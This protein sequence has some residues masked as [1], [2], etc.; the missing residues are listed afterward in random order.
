MRPW[1]KCSRADGAIR[2]QQGVIRVI[3]G[4]AAAG[5]ILGLAG[6]LALGE[7]GDAQAQYLL[8]VMRE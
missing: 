1:A 5:L 2:F 8:G 3:V 7:D 4:C 6:L